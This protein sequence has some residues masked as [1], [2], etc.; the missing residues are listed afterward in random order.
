MVS[1]FKNSFCTSLY[2]EWKLVNGNDDF[3]TISASLNR[4]AITAGRQI[5]RNLKNLGK[6]IA[7]D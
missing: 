7:F 6:I 4:K 3:G 5:G 1:G 2:G